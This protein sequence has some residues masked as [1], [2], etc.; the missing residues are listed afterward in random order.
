MKFHTR[1]SVLALALT[2]AVAGTGAAARPLTSPSS[3]LFSCGAIA[4][5]PEIKRVESDIP[6]EQAYL[7]T[8]IPY[9]S[10]AL[11][12]TEAAID[13]LED[14]ERVIAIAEQILARHPDNLEE[15]A[16]IREEL[17]EN[18][19]I[20]K[21]TQEKMRIAMGG[22]ESCTDES[23][24]NYLDSEWVSDTFS[25]HDDPHFAYVS[26]MVLLLEMEMHQHMVG[27]E[28]AEHHEL[29]QFCERQVEEQTPYLEEL[30]VVRG[31]LFTRY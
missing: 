5:T 26:M 12:L 9:H 23:H 25:H 13:N 28:L 22:M 16:D 31:E 19:E 11:W 7:D 29:H 21:A 1:R 3:P 14:D 17:F 15:L 30:K 18:R 6:F 8:T 24:M 27:V 20:E 2:T 10:N 4:A